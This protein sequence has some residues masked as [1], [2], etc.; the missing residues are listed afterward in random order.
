MFELRV[1][2]HFDAAHNL[3][4]YHGACEHLHGHTYRVEIAL[5]AQELGS[6]GMLVDFKKIKSELNGIIDLLDHHYI[7]EV[8]PFDKLN[9]TAENLARYFYQKMKDALGSI[10]YQATVWETPG[11]S[12][13]YREDN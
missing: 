4:E 2:E 1:E 8:P 6:D 5:H 11:S 12:A 9:P 13:A 10:V 7:N 3:R